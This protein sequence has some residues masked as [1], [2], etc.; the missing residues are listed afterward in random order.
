MAALREDE[1]GQWEGNACPMSDIGHCPL[2]IESH[3]GRGRG[4]VDD[5]AQR[6]LV[7]R[8]KM[9]FQTAL[10]ALASE[11]VAHPGMIESL[12]TVGGRH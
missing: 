3:V 5:M 12:N 7:A 1:W 10:L 4:C 11:G 8:G 9:N 6:C 2:Y